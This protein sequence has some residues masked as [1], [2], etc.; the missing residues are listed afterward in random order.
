MATAV[1]PST[2]LALAAQGTW[3]PPV[4][5]SLPDLAP[6]RPHAS[7]PGHGHQSVDSNGER[8]AHADRCG[9]S[10][11]RTKKARRPFVAGDVPNPARIQDRRA[12][13]RTLAGRPRPLAPRGLHLPRPTSARCGRNA[14][15]VRA[16]RASTPSPDS[17]VG[18]RPHRPSRQQ[19]R[20][21]GKSRP[22]AGA[23]AA[24]AIACAQRDAATGR[25][26][27]RLQRWPAQDRQAPHRG[28]WRSPAHRRSARTGAGRRI[29]PPRP[30]RF[31]ERPRVR[32]CGAGLAAHRTYRSAA[33]GP[34]PCED[35]KRARSVWRSRVRM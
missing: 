3:R 1:A 32:R 16:Q 35:H 20:A 17:K 19:S 11:R 30:M 21:A 23:G 15:H 33:F 5:A 12:R 29:L 25:A 34:C 2:T 7:G 4:S 8:H 6:R 22:D 24:T 31:R 13:R 14:E 28:A 10:K 18:A 9:L 26:S 27:G